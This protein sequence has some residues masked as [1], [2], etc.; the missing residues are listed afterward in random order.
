VVFN[1]N[2][3]RQLDVALVHT[4]EHTSVVVC[5]RFSSD[6]KY[7]ATGCN[8]TAQIFDVVTG[9]KTVTLNDHSAESEGDLYVRAV[10]FSP[11]GLYLATG[12]EDRVVRIWDIGRRKIK[13][14]FIGHE[15]DIYSLE[16][17]RDGTTLASGSGDRTVR[18]W[19]MDTG[20][21]RLT[22]SIEDGV[23]SVAFSPDGKWL[24][25]GGLDR[26]IRV[27][28]TETGTFVQRLEGHKD[29]VYSVAFCLSGDELLSGSLD[30]TIKLWELRLT[31]GVP[32]PPRPGISK[33]T[34]IG[35]NDFVLSVAQSPDA[36]WVISGSKD[37]GVQFWNLRDG[38]SH[39]VLEGHHNSGT[40]IPIP[41]CRVN[42]ILISPLLRV[43]GVISRLSG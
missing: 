32:G 24:A 15:N 16:F 8:R 11:D 12:G 36:K 3:P 26:A 37:R 33:T 42:F 40:T 6:G 43:D 5:I 34:L 21:C 38:Q 35:H 30:K 22:L 41:E 31:M 13:N 39:F 4:F 7:L 19:D 23:T 20:H 25:A 27:W 10:C 1:S 17:S 29:S 14:A 2:V 9:R 18:L 28:D